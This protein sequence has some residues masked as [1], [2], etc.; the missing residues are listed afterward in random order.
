MIR[1]LRKIP[2]TN[3]EFQRILYSDFLGNVRFVKV[4]L[5]YVCM[6]HAHITRVSHHEICRVV[7]RT[8]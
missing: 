1:V 4:M 5:H 6:L 3:R 8:C 7:S 2:E